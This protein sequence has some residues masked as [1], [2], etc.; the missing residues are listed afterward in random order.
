MGK[1]A[2][3]INI[4]GEGS[5]RY[6]LI[7]EKGTHEDDSD[8]DQKRTSEFIQVPGQTGLPPMGI[9]DL[10]LE[11]M[12]N[13]FECMR[14]RQQPHATVHAGFAHSVACMMA[15]ESYWTGKKIFWDGR[16]ETFSDQKPA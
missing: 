1:K 15:A 16:S 9:D 14:S 7:E 4:G 6:Q 10:S 3:L 12:A 13:W 5:P 11:H 8:I 2:T